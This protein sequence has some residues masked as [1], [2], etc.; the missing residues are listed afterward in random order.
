VG[1][2]ADEVNDR[3]RTTLASDA[4]ALAW[5]TERHVAG[6]P[7][8]VAGDGPDR[9]VA[10]ELEWRRAD[11]SDNA[12]KLF[13]HLSEGTIDA[14]RLLVVHLFTRYY[15]L[16]SGGH[17]SKRKNAEFVGRMAARTLDSL[18]YHPVTFDLDPPKRGADRPEGWQTAADAA[19]ERVGGIID[20][21]HS[22]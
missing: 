13:R 16:A 21:P 18:S 3:L 7:V 10:V 4:P 12:A 15:D 6:T 9:L 2:F 19:V 8:D 17:S 5:S 1:R 11:P 14:D 20:G 22:S